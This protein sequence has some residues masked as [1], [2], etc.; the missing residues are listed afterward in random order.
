VGKKIRD[1]FLRTFL[2]IDARS[3]GLFRIVFA[4]ALLGDLFRRWVWVKEFYSNEGV[5]PNHNHL[6]LLRDKVQIWSALH[7]FSSPL[8]GHFAF[9]LILVVY[10]FFLFGVRTRVAHAVSLVCLV[11]LTGRNILLENA[12]NYAAIALL[13]FTLF[14]PLG[15]R[16]SIDALRASLRAKDEKDAAALNDR[17]PV[18]ETEV[19]AT[20]G[21]GWSPVSLAALAVTLQIALI[22]LSSALRHTAPAWKDGSALHY[23]LYVERWVSGLGASARG[24]VPEGIFRGLSFLML[25]TEWAVPVLVLI[26]VGRRY[27][28]GVAFGLLVA[29]SLIL[30]IFFSLGLYAWTLLAASALLIPDETWDA[31]AKRF[32]PRRALTVIYDADCGICLL[33]SRLMKRLDAHHHLAF[34]GNDDL[35]GLWRP[36][37]DGTIERVALPAAVTADLVAQT[38]VAVNAEGQVFTRGRA[39]A[40][41]LRAVPAGIPKSIFLRLPG[42]AQLGDA[43]YDRIAKRRMDI[44]AAM[45]LGACGVPVKDEGAAEA[46]PIEVAPARR[47]MRVLTGSVREIGVALLFVATLAQTAKENPLPS[48]MAIP[49]GK[50]LASVVAFPRMMAR[51]DVLAVAPEDGAFVIDGQNRKG[52]SIDLLTGGEPAAEPDS[53]AVR[54]LGQLWN[55]YLYRLHL[56]EWEPFQRAFRDYLAKGG[57][58]LEEKPGDEALAGFD[59][60]WMRYTIAPPGAAPARALAGRDKLFSHSRGGLRLSADRLP[61][62]RPDLRKPE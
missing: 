19:L 62:L 58:A 39:V 51:W 8:E 32:T 49:Q 7:A 45:G 56:K 16:F 5:L 36:K 24:H 48:A 15:S 61:L 57:P 54:R 41:I 43:I 27:T 18:A 22:L 44:S 2:R 4:L 17:T 13:F 3:L 29:Y 6:F 37:A 53:I 46:E 42:I 59:A 10:L 25:A 55:D 31:L 1:H 40:E 11:S 9:A 20:R 52:Q 50:L 35:E 14:L 12:G 28:R 60:Y 23:A 38:V 21:P 47:A 34:Q 26:P 30:G 33:I